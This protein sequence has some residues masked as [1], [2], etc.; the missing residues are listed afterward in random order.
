MKMEGN[1]ILITGGA[2]GIGLALVESLL[3]RGNEVIICGRRENRLIEV[4]N[5][6]PGLHIRVCDVSDEDSRK[7]LFKWVT[8]NFKDLNILINN[9]GIQRA[10]DLKEGIKGLEGENEIKINLEATIYLSTLFIPFLES[11]KEAAIVNISSGL[12]ITPLA[13]VPIYCATKAGV[14]TFTKCLRSQLS[15]TSIKVFEVLPPIVIS[16]LNMEYRKKVGTTNTGIK[17]DKCAASIVD[18]LEKDKFEIENPALENL[19]TA[20]MKD[21]DKLF[22]KMNGRW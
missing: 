1:T 10:I 13:A 7:S 2:T 12:A 19:K 15:D 5:E 20:T 18:G 16:E 4:Q 21:I 11:K 17:S 22:E 9:A 14:H 6:H 3:E 8:K